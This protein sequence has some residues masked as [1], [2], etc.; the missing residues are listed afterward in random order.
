MS[1]NKKQNKKLKNYIRENIVKVFNDYPNKIMNYKQIA[2]TIN[3]TDKQSRKLLLNTLIE[4]SGEGILKETERGKFAYIQSVKNITG[5]IELT[6]RGGG[7]VITDAFD[8]DIKVASKDLNTAF[9]GDEVEVQLL[10]KKRSDS[11]K[12]G[13]ITKIITRHKQF[14]VGT[15]QIS[16]GYA[17]VIPDNNKLSQD[18]Y[19]DTKNINGAKDGQKVI[20]KFLD[21]PNPQK[22]PFGEITE[23]LGAPGS[24]EAE[25][26]SILAEHDLPRKFPDN[27]IKE[28][29]KYTV[30]L[31]PTE[32]A[33]RRDFRSTLT[34]TIDPADAKDF[35]DAISFEKL[36]SGHYSI[37]VHIADVGHY[38]QP[39][40]A[41]DKEAYSRGN[42]VYLVDRVIPMLPE[43]LSNLV[44][45]LRPNEEKF[46]FSAVFEIDNKGKIY[47]EWF[48]K[49]VI[50][51]TKRYAYEQAQEIIEG[52][53]GDLDEEI[54]II[55]S[56]A[57]NLREKR[58][59]N[60]ALEISGEEF[61]FQLD[62]N[63]KP[64][65]VIR[66]VQKDAN[67]L[68]EEFMLLANK[69][70]TKF[71]ASKANSGKQI[72]FIYR[73]HDKP[74]MG[75]L[76]VFK[77]FISK[78]GL[79]ISFEN[80]NDIALKI[81]ALLNEIKG[82]SEYDMVQQ[83]V[84]KSMSKAEYSTNNIGHYGLHFEFYS[85]FTSPIRRYADLVVHRIL[86]DV[87]S[88]KATPYN[89]N[90]NET[91]KH[92][93]RT[94]RK[95]VEAERD[96]NKFFQALYMEDKVGGIFE[97]TVTGIT[98]WGIYARINEFACEGMIALD[99]IT[100]DH[101]YF[102][103]KKYRI[104]GSS[105]NKEYNLGDTIKVQVVRVD[106]LERKIDFEIPMV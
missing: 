99:S 104:I 49:G 39:G 40:T 43:Q 51:S 12:S 16:K 42:S 70:V 66:K 27:V 85:H 21:W 82:K 79:K 14:F 54:K 24:N 84:I 71:V 101:Y 69:S 4:M 72:P 37:G 1:K 58:I 48:G 44:C 59:K 75:K 46:V 23:I 31:D 19:I 57:K 62:E 8:D 5:I 83:M 89:K 28:A 29:E 36:E 30:E 65:G 74:D 78:F 10:P 45:S 34:F 55:D 18:F 64:I 105:K 47:N 106:T 97:A 96:S 80:E 13:I 103:E 87:L 94:E 53:T 50:C 56:I 95:A 102:D 98:N 25:I 100:D 38:V 68:V 6:Q 86:F 93:S 63:G 3:L 92:I 17:F 52:G 90:L 77:T 32:I 81:N 35:D 22:S 61:R 60:G 67:K 41:L 9:D 7:Y 20:V 33:K 91:A 73:I 88:E 2:A 11:K 76:D 26:L 15:V